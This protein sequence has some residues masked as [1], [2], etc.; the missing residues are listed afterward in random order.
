MIRC[1]DSSIRIYAF[2]AN[3]ILINADRC[4]LRREKNTK[5]VAGTGRRM[6]G[7]SETAMKKGERRMEYKCVLK[8]YHTLMGPSRGME[9]RGV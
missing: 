8:S 5:E 7:G 2:N 1:S 4:F 9:T 6:D 3:H